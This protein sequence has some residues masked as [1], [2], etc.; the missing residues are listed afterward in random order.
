MGIDARR[1]LLG[2]TGSFL[3]ILVYQQLKRRKSR[4]AHAGS[5]RIAAENVGM[6][7]VFAKS[8]KF[9]M[10]IVFKNRVAYALLSAQAG[11]LFSR[12]IVSVLVARLDGAIVQALVSGEK[13]RF[14]L[15]LQWWILVALPATT[16]NAL[17]RC[18]Q[19]RIA[20]HCRSELTQH[21]LDKYL[22][23]DTYYKLAQLDSRITNADQLIT[24]DIER[25]S[26]SLSELYSNLAKPI[27]DLI[28]FGSQLA[29][30][31]GWIGPASMGAFYI[32][33]G[34]SLPIIT[35]PFGRLA[36]EEGRLEGEYRAAH[37][38]LI[39]NAEEIAFY[40][41][42]VIEKGALLDRY[43]QLV[44][45]IYD[46]ITRRIGFAIIEG[47]MLKYVSSATGLVICALPVFW[48]SKSSA[49]LGVGERTADY[50]RNRRYLLN[51]A[52]AITRILS[53]TKEIGELA[54]YTSR[55]ISLLETL[56]DVNNQ[57]FVKQI[58]EAN[59]AGLSRFTGGTI[60]FSSGAIEF[61]EVPIITP[62]GDELVTS[63]TM[64]IEKGM[65]TLI[66]GPNGCG[67]SS[68]FRILG[69]LWPVRH[70]IL[71]RP[72][73][74]DL[75][76]I[77]QRP[78]LSSGNFRDQVIYPDTEL[79]MREKGITDD[80]IFSL[81]GFAHL[82]YVLER[83]GGW[84]SMRDWKDVLSG[85][86]KQRVAMARLFYHKPR[87]A[88]LDECTSQVSIDVEGLMYTHATELGITLMTVSH[89]PSLWKYHN[90]VCQFDGDGGVELT[91]LDVSHRMSLEEEKADIIKKLSD[92]PQLNQR[93]D[94]IALQLGEVSKSAS[95]L[96]LQ[97][98][99]RRASLPDQGA[100]SNPGL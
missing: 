28:L 4:L 72:L 29:I 96:D 57:V 88:I 60:E 80:D 79:K 22:L 51:L 86:E 35:P 98:H 5:K 94:A 27:L 75:F 8:L 31:V 6:N 23:N 67:K 54:G 7:K 81:L 91:P 15:L 9:L 99:F 95:H 93:L 53:S 10:K 14:L 24:V 48:S 49:N 50:T 39:T 73:P 85:G 63:L 21:V 82:Q 45:H 17:I 36:A 25:F 33:Y 89:R 83:E 13:A 92:V 19:S 47:F 58:P 87:F 40:K 97:E 59:Q 2:G 84:A 90:Y 76:Y 64:V 11:L 37:A 30:A 68:L 77:P 65:H 3:A 43:T 78:Y 52:D 55:V 12:T 20:L 26:S 74:S 69:G 18:L 66:T 41:G 1:I 46:I 71:R 61:D 38:R 56:D 16:I 100:V 70:G 34:I 44:A 32:A 62:N 42:E